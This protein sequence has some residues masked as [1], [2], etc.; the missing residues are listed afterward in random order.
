MPYTGVKPT[1]P[2]VNRSHPLAQGLVGAWPIQDGGGGILRDASGQGRD[3]ALYTWA[4]VPVPQFKQTPYG[5]GIDPSAKSTALD[6]NMF[7]GQLGRT[8][9]VLFKADSLQANYP[10][11]SYGPGWTNRWYMLLQTDGTIDTRIGSAVAVT[12]SIGYSV[13]EWI[14]YVVTYDGAYAKAYINGALGSSQA[15]STLVGDVAGRPSIGGL[16]ETV[17]VLDGVIA[18]VRIWSRGLK[19]SEVA[20]L[21]QDPWALYRPARP[22]RELYRGKAI[23]AAVKPKG[24]KLLQTSRNFSMWQTGFRRRR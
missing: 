18:D 19:S 3:A 16:N 13:G 4:G 22:V 2:V 21:Y 17:N 14:H 9:S 1:N 23:A 11:A 8:V 7:V 10:F 24:N 12:S 6:V 20:D 15:N 5:G